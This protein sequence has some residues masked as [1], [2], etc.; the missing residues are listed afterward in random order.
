V[1]QKVG[2]SLEKL[3]QLYQNPST[4]ISDL[5]SAFLQAQQ[6][7]FSREKLK[8]ETQAKP[9]RQRKEPSQAI[10]DP[11]EQGWRSGL[12][13]LQGTLESR[14]TLPDS[15][16]QVKEDLGQ[17]ATEATNALRHLFGSSRRT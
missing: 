1:S 13:K 17:V 15:L 11:A 12:Q 7:Y 5:H 10:L 4:K 8:E 14:Y 2:K 3:R 16:R 9:K 6:E